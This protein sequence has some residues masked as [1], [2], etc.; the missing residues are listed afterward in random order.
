MRHV[1]IKIG[2]SAWEILKQTDL[3]PSIHKEGI[4]PNNWGNLSFVPKSMEPYFGPSTSVTLSTL[5]LL[6]ISVRALRPT[7]WFCE[8][9]T[10]SK[11]TLAKSSHHQWQLKH[12]LPRPWTT[13]NTFNTKGRNVMLDT[14]PLFAFATTLYILQIYNILEKNS[15][16][17]T[18]PPLLDMM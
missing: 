11:T 12:P 9:L 14:T 3:I 5:N 13:F 1:H 6:Q 15:R 7:K 16:K 10:F 8:P 4:T 17:I 18:H 2:F